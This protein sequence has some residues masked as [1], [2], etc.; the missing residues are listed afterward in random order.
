MLVKVAK[1]YAHGII[2][3]ISKERQEIPLFASL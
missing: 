3:N 1:V 2:I